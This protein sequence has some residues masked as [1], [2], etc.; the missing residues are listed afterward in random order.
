LSSF[1]AD[2]RPPAGVVLV[3]VL[4]EGVGVVDFGGVVVFGG[5][6][7]LLLGLVL[8][9]ALV[10]L[11]V[12]SSSSSESSLACFFERRELPLIVSVGLAQA[13]VDAE[14]A[15]NSTSTS[16]RMVMRSLTHAACRLETSRSL[17]FS[18]DSA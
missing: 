13:I 15:T 9:L 10:L 5:V 11:P 1:P 4:V 6:V 18:D 17:V 12:L 8:L 16:K 3:L 14:A 2:G 7:L